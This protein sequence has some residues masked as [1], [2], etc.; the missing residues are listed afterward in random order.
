MGGILLCA[1]R[2]ENDGFTRREVDK[3]YRIRQLPPCGIFIAG[4]GPANVISKT[5]MEIES[6]LLRA[7]NDDADLPSEHVRIIEGTLKAIHKQYAA[8]LKSWAMQLIVIVALRNGPTILYKTEGAMLVQEHLYVAFGTGQTLADYFA[9]RLYQYGRLDKDSMKVMAAFILREAEKAADGVGPA[10]MWFIHEG[11]QTI[12]MLSPGS[13]KEIQDC[14][15][16]L[17]ESLW[18]D[19]KN[20]VNLPSRLAG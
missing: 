17:T 2:E 9:D 11:D 6:A 1:D 5:E 12:H 16:K 14:I 13:V 15:P 19:W 8:N 3:I 20:R 4:A 18:S 10:D 7:F